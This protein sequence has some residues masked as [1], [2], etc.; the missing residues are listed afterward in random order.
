MY[1]VVCYW[2]GCHTYDGCEVN[3]FMDYTEAYN[4]MKKEFMDILKSYKITYNTPT[5]VSN[6]EYKDEYGNLTD[7]V[8]I[9]PHS[10]WVNLDTLN[11]EDR[12]FFS[13]V[14]KKIKF[15]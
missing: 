3:I 4:Y 1:I 10:A 15:E 6:A 9:D 7:E 13:L 2:Y 8:G 11:Y 5:P 14:E 12:I